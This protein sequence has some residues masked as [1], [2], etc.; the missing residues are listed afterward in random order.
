MVI[1]CVFSEKE[2]G[3][4]EKFLIGVGIS[5]KHV[6][7][8]QEHFEALFGAGAAMTPGKPLSQPGQW[9][10]A[11]AVHVLGP[12]GCINN[13]RIVG[14][15]RPYSQ[16][17]LSQTD[18][19]RLGVAA[20]LRNSGDVAGSA[21]C[22]LAGPK[23]YLILKEGAII[24][25]PHVHLSSA[26]GAALQ[27]KDKDRVDIYFNGAKKAAYFDIMVRVGDEHEADIHIDTDE[28]NAVALAPGQK[29]LLVKK[30]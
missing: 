30:G 12:K 13:L 11:E 17:E 3:G 20:P 2:F 6:H 26:Q 28:A 18:A 1:M 9:A 27:L 15:A 29:G 25:R 23:G 10:A 14:P 24:A 19:I 21:S 22:V 16:V 5:N 4:D 7:L 8:T